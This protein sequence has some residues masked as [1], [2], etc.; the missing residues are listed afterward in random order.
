MG[1]ATH[2]KTTTHKT[3]KRLTA[4]VERALRAR[5]VAVADAARHAL[6]R[7]AAVRRAPR[8]L[9][10]ARRQTLLE[11]VGVQVGRPRH[12][13][14]VLHPPVEA[15][16][17]GRAER[18]ADKRHARAVQR[19]RQRH[20]RVAAHVPK[21]LVRERLWRRAAR[22]V[23]ELGL[24]E[25]DIGDE[26]AVGSCVQR[27]HGEV[28]AGAAG[29][30]G[31]A[32]HGLNGD[33]LRE[34]GADVEAADQ[35]V[36]A[37]LHPHAPRAVEPGR[38]VAWRVD[39]ERQPAH[40][41]EEDAVEQ[42]P[43]VGV[44]DLDI[45]DPA[46]GRVPKLH[47]VV[48]LLGVHALVRRPRQAHGQVLEADARARVRLERVQLGVPGRR[49]V[50]LQVARKADVVRPDLGHLFFVFSFCVCIFRRVFR[51]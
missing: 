12:R 32:L 27:L 35:H 1:S 9:H 41:E 29:D 3:E 40:G 47:R 10:E 4:I 31:A 46:V 33:V 20:R 7:R 43:Q 13:A 50:V 6:A 28:A 39:A 38:R 42:Q 18:R 21:R 51:V 37:V 22:R 5:G 15:A 2:K 24:P 30:D 11:L 19:A 23:G 8:L 45:V 26:R 17:D 14:V 48:P 49:D 36:G 44:D 34:R 25:R 16:R